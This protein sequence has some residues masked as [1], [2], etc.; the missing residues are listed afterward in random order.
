MVPNICGASIW[1][2]L[3]VTFLVPEFLGGFQ[4][5][6]NFMNPFVLP[7]GRTSL[8]RRLEGTLTEPKRGFVIHADAYKYDP[9]STG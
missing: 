6:G 9:I 3:Q 5:S 4:I 7:D 8:A 1:H 2:F